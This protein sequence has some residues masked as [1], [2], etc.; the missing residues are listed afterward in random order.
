MDGDDMFRF[1]VL[2]CVLGFV[3][4]YSALISWFLGQENLSFSVVWR[5][6][7]ANGLSSMAWLD[8]VVTALVLV[9]F[10]RIEG[11]RREMPNLLP[12]ILGTCLVG[13]SFGLPLF[14]LM[15]ERARPV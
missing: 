3:L 2:M 9:A 14:L 15:R 1:Y 4:P 6:L 12:P 7:V 5:D 10:I 11:K 8:V 13:P